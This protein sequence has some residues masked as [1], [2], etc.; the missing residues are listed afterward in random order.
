[1]PKLLKIHDVHKVLLGCYKINKPESH[2]DDMCNSYSKYCIDVG[3][4]AIF[5]TDNSGEE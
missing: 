3:G 2:L 1:M 4:E 5:S